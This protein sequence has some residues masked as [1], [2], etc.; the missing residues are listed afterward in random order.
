[1]PLIGAVQ[2]RRPRRARKSSGDAE[3]IAQ[4]SPASA[5]GRERAE[6]RGERA[7]LAVERRGEML[8]EV[9]LVDVAA[10]DR[11]AHGLD[12][13]AVVRFGPRALPL[14]DSRRVPGTDPRTC[15]GRPRPRAAAG[16]APAAQARSC[17]AAAPRGRSRG[18][19]RPRAPRR[20][21]RRS[22][23][24]REVGLDRLERAARASAARARLRRASARGRAEEVDAEARDRPRASARRRSGSAGPPARPPSSS[25]GRSRRRP[26]RTPRG[27]SGSR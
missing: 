15:P 17:G 22:P 11:L 13:V 25:A 12:R 26:C 14:P 5:R 20:R 10:P 1:M 16:T 18:R 3:T 27:A 9:D 24:S 23:C 8:D 19:D 21:A 7:R 4:P 2:T 6:P